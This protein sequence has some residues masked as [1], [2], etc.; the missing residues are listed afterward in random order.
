[1]AD[2]IEK[3]IQANDVH[4]AYAV[5][6]VTKQGNIHTLAPDDLSDTPDPSGFRASLENRF[7]DT[8]YYTA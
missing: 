8:T 2:V 5:T 3:V 7:D 4:N 6:G 1:M